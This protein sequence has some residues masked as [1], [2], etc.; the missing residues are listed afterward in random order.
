MNAKL[1]YA[2]NMVKDYYVMVYDTAV[3]KAKQYTDYV[4]KYKEGC[5]VLTGL[6]VVAGVASAIVGDSNK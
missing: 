4:F 3:Y 2:C 1:E 6:V 5:A